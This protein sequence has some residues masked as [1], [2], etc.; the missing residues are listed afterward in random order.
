MSDQFITVSAT[1]DF[2]SISSL[3]LTKNSIDAGSF[4]AELTKP[5][6][7]DT[8]QGAD[9]NVSATVAGVDFKILSGRVHA[10]T[11]ISAHDARVTL[12]GSWNTNQTNGA[13]ENPYELDLNY[14]PDVD[15]YFVSPKYINSIAGTGWSIDP[16][17]GRIKTKDYYVNGYHM[18]GRFVD[19]PELPKSDVP[20]TSWKLLLITT[21]HEAADYL[22]RHGGYRI[23]T[24][25][26]NMDILTV[27]KIPGDQ[28]YWSSVQSI[29]S[30]WNPEHQVLPDKSGQIIFYV[31]D[32]LVRW[33]SGGPLEGGYP[34]YLGSLV[35]ID[36]PGGIGVQ[37][38]QDITTFLQDGSLPLIDHST[39]KLPAA[40]IDKFSKE[41]SIDVIGSTGRFSAVADPTRGLSGNPSDLP[42]NISASMSG[43]QP[44]RRLKLGEILDRVIIRGAKTDKSTM[45]V[46]NKSEAAGTVDLVPTELQWNMERTFT[47]SYNKGSDQKIFGNFF[48]GFDSVDAAPIVTP[49]RGVTTL[50][51]YQD[52]FNMAK[53]VPMETQHEKYDLLGRLVNRTLSV[54]RYAK[55]GP[56]NKTEYKL[57]DTTEKEWQ[58]VQQPGKPY[59]ELMLCKNRIVSQ[60]TIVSGLNISL[61]QELVEQ[62]VMVDKIKDKITGETY[63]ANPQPLLQANQNRMVVSN[64]A[65]TQELIDMTTSVKSC[66]L[67]RVSRNVLWQ[68]EDEYD[69]ISD[70]STHR[71]DIITSPDE[72]KKEKKDAQYVK[73][74]DK[75]IGQ[76]KRPPVTVEHPDID[77]DYKAQLVADR[78]YGKYQI[79]GAYAQPGLGSTPKGQYETA[80]VDLLFPLPTILLGTKIRVANSKYDIYDHAGN[81]ETVEITA[82]LYQVDGITMGLSVSGNGGLS[83]SENLKVIITTAD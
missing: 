62:K 19:I 54:N 21:H 43:A 20:A 3:S 65:T 59:K 52:P 44:W 47:D 58:L 46:S 8:V 35:D 28:T 61:K 30:L 15:L 66:R 38:Q 67:D 77:N 34:T 14:C 83:I 17:T 75:G 49:D 22:A 40:F 24:N 32:I 4:S 6:A 7:V 51:Y 5:Q 73:V 33:Q 2:G 53:I 13:D 12:K 78:V 55:Q 81:K 11:E 82:G 69:R 48:G 42:G 80:S 76:R 16:S 23:V 29:F 74:F 37:V 26:P 60:C 68:A 10:G 71:D 50:R 36:N 1:C 31:V 25:T 63:Y 70:V 79:K 57:V 39:I 18:A 56:P 9:I 64:A 72:F 27:L 45:T 41:P